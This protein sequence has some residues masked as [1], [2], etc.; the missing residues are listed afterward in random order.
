[1]V[2]VESVPAKLLVGVLACDHIFVVEGL[3]VHSQHAF[4]Q[5]T[6]GFFLLPHGNRRLLLVKSLLSVDLFLILYFE[7]F[8][9]IATGIALYFSLYWLP[10]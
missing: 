2:G 6:A 7:Y 1:M 8:Y 9:V 5:P 10:V 3:P 4:G